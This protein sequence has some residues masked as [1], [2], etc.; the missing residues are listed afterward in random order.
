[1]TRVSTHTLHGAVPSNYEGLKSLLGPSGVLKDAGSHERP[2]GPAAVELGLQSLIII[3]S[4]TPHPRRHRRHTRVVIDAT[5]ASS[6]T[7]HPRRHRRHTHVVIDATHASSSTPHTRRHRGN[8]DP[9]SVSPQSDTR[10]RYP[11]ARRSP[12]RHPPRTTTPGRAAA[13]S[14]GCAR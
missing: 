13:R 7:P 10:S 11:T 8:T 4:S 6:S 14:T 9:L 1:M 5:P 12:P 3:S 2:L